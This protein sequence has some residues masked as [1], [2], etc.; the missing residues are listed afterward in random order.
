MTS[1][2][3]DSLSLGARAAAAFSAYREGDDQRMG[4]L[5]ELLTPV[6]W[7][8]ARAQGATTDQADEAVQTAWLALVTHA[9]SVRE[10]MAVL[11]WMVRTVKRESWRLV[12][13]RR[14]TI[15]IAEPIEPSD[16]ARHAPDAETLSILTERQRLLW[17][18]VE[19]LSPRCAELLKVIAFVDRPDYAQVSRALGMPI[20]S[21]GPTRGRCLDKLRA[22]LGADLRW[23][24]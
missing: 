20:G 11:A 9:E 5:V 16:P 12:A 10:P 8:V 22:A 4:E 19:Q 14:R 24:I 21:I 23:G 6:M 3:R 18:H 15:P 17:D 1:T 13:A 2:N 7:R